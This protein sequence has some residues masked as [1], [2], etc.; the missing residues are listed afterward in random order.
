M[1]PTNQYTDANLW[2]RVKNGDQGAFS[3]I[4]ERY[5][6]LLYSHVINK[7]DDEDEARDIVQDIF[8][9]L[10][11]KRGTIHEVNIAGY[12]FTAARNKVL[13]SIRHKKIISKFE[14]DFKDFAGDHAANNVENSIYKRE[15][16]AMI[17][18]EIAALP[19]RMREVFELSRKGCLP[20]QEIADQLGISKHTVNDHIKASLKILRLKVKMAIVF[21]LLSGI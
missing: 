10:W 9:A 13:N 15:L 16:E 8:V 12:L 19:E 3:E 17:E 1:D 14:K 18:M 2:L 5:N 4:F 20:H 7:L 6:A 11:E 21:I